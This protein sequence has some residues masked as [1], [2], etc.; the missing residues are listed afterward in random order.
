MTALTALA[1]ATIAPPEGVAPTSVIEAAIR[2]ACAGA[3]RA[4][5]VVLAGDVLRG[6]L[7]KTRDAIVRDAVEGLLALHGKVGIRADALA[8]L[9]AAREAGA[10]GGALELETVIAEI[11]VQGAVVVGRAAVAAIRKHLAGYRDLEVVLEGD[12]ATLL[13]DAARAIFRT[14]ARDP[15]LARWAIGPTG[16]PARDRAPVGVRRARHITGVDRRARDPDRR[17]D[18]ARRQRPVH[19]LSPTR[20]RSGRW[21]Q[22]LAF[23]HLAERRPGEDD[24]PDPVEEVQRQAAAMLGDKAKHYAPVVQDSARRSPPKAS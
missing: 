7:G 19:G 24:L 21:H 22:L 6:R 15:E 3:W 2:E 1:A 13:V 17:P 16:S 18:R 5:E 20:D 14:R 4:V 23:A 10:L 11:R 9:R 12:L 8:A